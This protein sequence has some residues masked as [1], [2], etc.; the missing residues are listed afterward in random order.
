M[1]GGVQLTCLVLLPVPCVPVAHER[2]GVVLIQ[3]QL[4]QHGLP[5]VGRAQRGGGLTPAPRAPG[6]RLPTQALGTVTCRGCTGGR[7]A[8]KSTAPG[9]CRG[10]RAG[11]ESPIQAGAGTGGL[12]SLTSGCYRRPDTRA[13]HCEL[14]PRTESRR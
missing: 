8:L 9:L 3:V 11:T 1:V 13:S 6:I 14:Q 10:N 12:G 5:V 2:A 7:V 4:G